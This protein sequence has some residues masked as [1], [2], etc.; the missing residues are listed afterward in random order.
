MH[1]YN[2]SESDMHPFIVARGPDIRNIG[3][4]DTFYQ[5]DVY[6]LIC[7][8]L[9]I[10]VPNVVDG[11]VMRVATFAKT[12]PSQEVLNQ[13]NRYAKGLDPLPGGSAMLS[14]GEFDI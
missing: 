7:L 12:L 4:V 5:V 1:G 3:Q 10:Y 9:K 6:A 8:L 11:D 14:G 2:N 13:F